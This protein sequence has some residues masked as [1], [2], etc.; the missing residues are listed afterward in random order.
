ME[1][2]TTGAEAYSINPLPVLEKERNAAGL[3]KDGVG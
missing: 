3:A 2:K 1:V